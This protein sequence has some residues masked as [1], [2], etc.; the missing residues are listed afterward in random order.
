MMRNP[1]HTRTLAF[2][3]I[4][5]PST[6]PVVG[7][8][9]RMCMVVDKNAGAPAAASGSR[10]SA[11]ASHAEGAVSAEWQWNVRHRRDNHFPRAPA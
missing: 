9:S 3:I 11:G 10:K 1:K 5:R 6:S 7:G 2:L 4:R 8:C